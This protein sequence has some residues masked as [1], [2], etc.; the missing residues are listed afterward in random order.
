MGDLIMTRNNDENQQPVERVEPVN[1]EAEQQVLGILLYDHTYLERIAQTLRAEHFAYPEHQAI[2][3]AILAM[4]QD[5][6]IAD[7]V[8]LGAYMANSGRTSSR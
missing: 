7:P 8:T 2:Y 6:E 3:G 1:A 5:G 4:A